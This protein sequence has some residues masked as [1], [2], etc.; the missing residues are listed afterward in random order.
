MRAVAILVGLILIG[1]AI[2][3]LVNDKGETIVNIAKGTGDAAMKGAKGITNA[4]A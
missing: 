3:A 2:W 4:F 1:G